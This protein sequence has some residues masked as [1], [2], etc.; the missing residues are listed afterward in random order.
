MV[1]HRIVNTVINNMP[2]ERVDVNA[3]LAMTYYLSPLVTRLR[4]NIYW[5]YKNISALG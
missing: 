5:K 4:K 2:T 1:G 3:S